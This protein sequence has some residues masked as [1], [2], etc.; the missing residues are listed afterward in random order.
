MAGSLGIRQVINQ[1]L[2]ALGSG[3]LTKPFAE[4]KESGLVELIGINEQVD[5]DEYSASVGV[6]LGG[7]YSGEILM[8][9]LY[10]TEDG[11]GAVQEPD[12]VL[13]FLDIDPE[14]AAGDAALTA[15]E[16]VTIIGQIDVETDDWQSDANGASACIKNQPLTFHS[17]AT[18]YAVW[19]HKNATSFNDVAGDDEQLEMNMWYRRDS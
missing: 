19:F 11:S 9:T 14:A 1:I 6:V 2:T 4:M 13:I 17:L 18:I 16:R 7:T 8:V 15:A 10:S 12:G 5:Q 3:V